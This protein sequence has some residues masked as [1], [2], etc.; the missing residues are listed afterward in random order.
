MKK[1]M[2]VFT[3]MIICTTSF[4]DVDHSEFFDAEVE[5]PEQVTR[6][7]LECHETAGQDFIKTAHWLWKGKTPF[8]KEHE[9]DNKFGKINLMNGY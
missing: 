9:T 1:I 7:C 8:V 3:S 6:A 2:I 4:A 5:T